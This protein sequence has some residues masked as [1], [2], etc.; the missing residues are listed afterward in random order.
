MW[1]GQGSLRVNFGLHGTRVHKHTHTHTHT[2]WNSKQGSAAVRWSRAFTGTCLVS[3]LS[4]L[5]YL[6]TGGRDAMMISMFLTSRGGKSEALTSAWSG[7]GVEL[8]TTAESVVSTS[9]RML[10][11]AKTTKGMWDAQASRE[12]AGVCVQCARE[13]VCVCVWDRKP[14]YE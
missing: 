12:C 11:S 2:Q 9:W 10:D 8:P 3:V 14:R 4:A 1:N 6:Q 5:A 7:Q 13:C